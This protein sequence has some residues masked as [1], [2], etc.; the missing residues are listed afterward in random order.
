MAYTVN[1]THRGKQVIECFE[2]FDEASFGADKLYFRGSC[3]CPKEIKDQVMIALGDKRKLNYNGFAVEFDL[4][5]EDEEMTPELKQKIDELLGIGNPLMRDEKETGK[6]TVPTIALNRYNIPNKKYWNGV[7]P[8]DVK[9]P[10]KASAAVKFMLRVKFRDDFAYI[11]FG[12][13]W[14]LTLE[15][16]SGTLSD[17]SSPKEFVDNFALLECHFISKEDALTILDTIFGNVSL[18]TSIANDFTKISIETPTT[19]LMDEN[20]FIIS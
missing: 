9:D 12:C 1:L 2:L 15:Y 10:E 20:G 18:V 11:T 19:E 16:G 6:V 17:K 4:L 14:E 5:K 8:T 7:V 13:P 3:C